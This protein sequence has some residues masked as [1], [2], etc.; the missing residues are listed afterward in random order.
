MPQA[1]EINIVSILR[2]ETGEQFILTFDNSSCGLAY[3]QLLRW[4][5][6]PE[7]DFHWRDVREMSKAV[8][9][10]FWGG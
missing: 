2:E 5:C 1:I 3:L 7:L 6:D 4:W 10:V 8:R 9:R